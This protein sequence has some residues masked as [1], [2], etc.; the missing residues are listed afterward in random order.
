MTDGMLMRQSRRS[1]PRNHLPTDD[2]FEKARWSSMAT[3]FPILRFW[4][5]FCEVLWP[6]V[7]YDTEVELQDRE[8]GTR[9]S[10][11]IVVAAKSFA[12]GSLQLSQRAGLAASGDANT[13]FKCSFYYTTRKNSFFGMRNENLISKLRTRPLALPPELSTQLSSITRHFRPLIPATFSYDTSNIIELKYYEHPDALPHCRIGRAPRYTGSGCGSIFVGSHVHHHFTQGET[14]DVNACAGPQNNPDVAAERNLSPPG[15]VFQEML[16]R[17]AYSLRLRERFFAAVCVDKQDRARRRDVRLEGH[18]AHPSSIPPGHLLWGRPTR[19]ISSIRARQMSTCAKSFA[20]FTS[21]PFEKKCSE[22][23]QSQLLH[24]HCRLGSRIFPDSAGADMSFITLPAPFDPEAGFEFDLVDI[25]IDLQQILL[26]SNVNVVQKRTPQPLPRPLLLVREQ[27]PYECADPDPAS[28]RAGR[29]GEREGDEGETNSN[30]GRSCSVRREVDGLLV[31]DQRLRALYMI[32]ALSDLVRMRAMGAYDARHAGGRRRDGERDDTADE[33]GGRPRTARGRGWRRGCVVDVEV[34]VDT[35]IEAGRGVNATMDVDVD[36]DT[37]AGKGV[38]ED[39]ASMDA[40]STSSMR[41]RRQ[42]HSRHGGRAKHVNHAGD[43]HDTASSSSKDE[44][45]GGRRK[46]RT[47]TQT[48]TQAA[49][50]AQSSDPADDEGENGLASTHPDGELLFL[51]PETAAAKSTDE[52]SAPSEVCEF[53]LRGREAPESPASASF[54]TRRNVPLRLSDQCLSELGGE[55]GMGCESGRKV[56]NGYMGLA[57][58]DRTYPGCTQD[59]RRKNTM[60]PPSGIKKIFCVVVLPDLPGRTAVGPWL[61]C[62]A[63]AAELAR[64][65]TYSTRACVRSRSGYHCGNGTHRSRP[66]SPSAHHRPCLHARKVKSQHSG[67]RPTAPPPPPWCRVRWGRPPPPPFAFALEARRSPERPRR[68]LRAVCCAYDARREQ[69]GPVLVSDSGIKGIRNKDTY[70]WGQERIRRTPSTAGSSCTL[71]RS[72][73][74]IHRQVLHF[75]CTEDWY[76]SCT[77]EMYS[78][79]GLRHSIH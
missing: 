47:P 22:G 8:P 59:C 24:L 18:E 21:K 39:D 9:V 77:G 38:G 19:A 2:K 72:G 31:I 11:L 5:E 57:N 60:G 23:P 6:P 34:D 42:R 10:T 35:V 67:R 75:R 45:E 37:D 29:E 12:A 33:E 41:R 56:G 48:K 51:H 76:G 71:R 1:D 27:T 63:L 61:A 16:Q 78:E 3:P 62:L 70:T 36:A 44:Q 64:P 50:H 43:E 68:E 79:T 58:A 13:S 28:E 52:A 55:D 49:A 20:F 14:R 73:L 54:R 7:S 74:L 66:P 25:L 4:S 65:S 17:G 26:V 46:K 69:A 15:S 53:V 40:G 30:S 32:N